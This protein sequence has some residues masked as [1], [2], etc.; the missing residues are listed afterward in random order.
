ML[1]GSKQIKELLPT[2]VLEPIQPI[3][4]S[5]T[6]SLTYTR[7]PS[8]TKELSVPYRSEVS[9]VSPLSLLCVPQRYGVLLT[10]LE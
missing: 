7:F 3:F 5:H 6:S 8:A 9:P 10:T 2:G 1:L 4:A